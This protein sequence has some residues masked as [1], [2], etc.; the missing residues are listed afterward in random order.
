MR[1]DDGFTRLGAQKTGK[2]LR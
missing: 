1:G 2:T